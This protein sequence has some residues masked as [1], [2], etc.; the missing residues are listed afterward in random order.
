[1][2]PGI[3]IKIQRK[4]FK[5]PS[6]VYHYQNRNSLSS[7]FSWPLNVV[8]PV[9]FLSLL[10][11]KIIGCQNKD[12][13]PKSIFKSKMTKEEISI[14]KQLKVVLFLAPH[15]IFRSPKIE[16]FARKGIK[17]KPNFWKREECKK[18]SHCNLEGWRLS[19]LIN[20]LCIITDV[21]N[22]ASTVE[23]RT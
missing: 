21:S 6:L 20:Q 2:P 13:S 12:P 7:W 15:Y 22:E 18:V 9:I 23:R 17:R 16:K 14:S 3:P 11:C 5:K 19:G 8:A 10:F 1:M 4:A